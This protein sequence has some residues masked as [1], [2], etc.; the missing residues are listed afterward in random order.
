MYVLPWLLSHGDGPLKAALESR[1]AEG[2]APMLEETDGAVIAEV[3][4]HDRTL[5]ALIYDNEAFIYDFV[6]D[7]HQAYRTLEDPY[8]LADRFERE[9]ALAM[10]A[11][12]RVAAYRRVRA[13]RRHFQLR[14]QQMDPR[15]AARARR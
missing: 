2:L 4:G 11:V 12:T 7:R 8:M 1:M 5:S 15:D 14:P 6:A 13:A 9:P 3:L 10:Q